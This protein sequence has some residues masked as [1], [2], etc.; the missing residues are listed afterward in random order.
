[1]HKR[2]VQSEIPVHF[3]FIFSRALKAL[4]PAEKLVSK[5]PLGAQYHV[6]CQRPLQ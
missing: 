3:L 4:R 6:L 5:L 1:M 2:E